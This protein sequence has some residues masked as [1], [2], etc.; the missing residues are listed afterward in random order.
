VDLSDPFASF[1]PG[2]PGEYTAVRIAG[3][4]AAPDTAGRYT[5]HSATP[6]AVGP[7]GAAGPTVDF[8]VVLYEAGPGLVFSIEE[9]ADS[10]WVG[11]FQQKSAGPLTPMHVKKEPLVKSQAKPKR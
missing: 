7:V 3:T 11:T 1:V 4:A 6:F 5:F 2:K 10:E 9:D 8:T